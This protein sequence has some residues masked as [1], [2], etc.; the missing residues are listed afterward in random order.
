MHPKHSQ[1][2]WVIGGSPELVSV[3][4]FGTPSS[5]IFELALLVSQTGPMGLGLENHKII[6]W[7]WNYLPIQKPIG[8]TS[9]QAIHRGPRQQ[10]SWDVPKVPWSFTHRGANSENEV[11]KLVDVGGHKSLGKF[12]EICTF[13]VTVTSDLMD[14][15][16][17]LWFVYDLYMIHTMIYANELLA[18]NGSPILLIIL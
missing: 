1:I 5:I 15:W 10:S 16:W 2:S 9:Q 12:H 6:L 3:L 17:P 4:R 18:N 8:P 14:L 11:L 13:W 7:L